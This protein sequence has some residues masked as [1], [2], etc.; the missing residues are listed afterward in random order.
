MVGVWRCVETETP[1]ILL[2]TGPV[3]SLGQL[4]LCRLRPSHSGTS[5]I[6]QATSD[7]K[8]DDLVNVL[9]LRGLHSLTT[10]LNL[11]HLKQSSGSSV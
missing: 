9:D 2:C 8:N 4:P 11:E 6:D 10:E 1:V 3:E 5:S 7:W